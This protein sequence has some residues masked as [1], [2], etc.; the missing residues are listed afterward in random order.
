MY[1][2]AREIDK[3]YEDKITKNMF[4]DTNKRNA[5]RDLIKVYFMRGGQEVQINCISREILKDA[6]ENP[7]NYGDMVAYRFAGRIREWLSQNF[8]HQY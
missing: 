1:N 8:N 5:L 6:M 4:T 7:E 3:I 2:K